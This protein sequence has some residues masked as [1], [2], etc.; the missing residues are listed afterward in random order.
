MNKRC[1]Q[2]G[3]TKNISEFASAGKGKKRAQCKPCLARKKREYYK[4]NPDKARRRNLLTYYGIT[5]EQYDEMISAQNNCCAVCLK[6]T[7]DLHVD[8]DHKTGKVRELLCINCN[9]AL[10]H[11]QDN[12]ERIIQLQHYVIKHQC[13]HLSSSSQQSC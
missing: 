13:D 5:V 1:T 3:E 7:D 8:H 2:C 6:Q 11:V 9:L 4:K 12:I 10:G